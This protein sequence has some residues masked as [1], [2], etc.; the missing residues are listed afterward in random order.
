[1]HKRL[2]CGFGRPGK[3]QGSWAVDFKAELEGC[4]WAECMYAAEL[5]EANLVGT[6]AVKLTICN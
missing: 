2:L 3:T 5:T 1:M 6:V 4:N